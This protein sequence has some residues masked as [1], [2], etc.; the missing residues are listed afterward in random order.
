MCAFIAA[1]APAARND[2]RSI[3]APPGPAFP[4]ARPVAF[5]AV[6]APATTPYGGFSTTAPQSGCSPT[7][8]TLHAAPIGRRPTVQASRPPTMTTLHT[9]SSSQAIV[10]QHPV[11]R[12]GDSG[13]SQPAVPATIATLHRVITDPPTTAQCIMQ[14]APGWQAP[15]AMMAVPSAMQPP[16]AMSSQPGNAC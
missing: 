14:P 8:A 7:M 2:G 16:G 15:A 10:V 5:G 13:S 12:P 6:A 3:C 1:P 9:S 4:L 11:S